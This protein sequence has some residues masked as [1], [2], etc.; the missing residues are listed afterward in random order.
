MG[1]PNTTMGED[2]WESFKLVG[3]DIEFLYSYLL[4][5]ETPLTSHELLAALI[6]ER[7]QLRRLEIERQHMAGGDLYQPKAKFQ[8]HQKLIFPALSWRQGEVVQVRAGENPEIGKFE[9][10]QVAFDDETH[11]EFAAS[12]SEHILNAPPK[13]VGEFKHL[14]I[15]TVLRI[16]GEDLNAALEEE[17]MTNSDFVR[18]AGRWFPRALLVDINVGHLN[19]A[20]AV[21]DMAS[22]GPLP[23]NNLLQQLE[24]TSEVNTKLQEFSMDHAL[25]EDPRFDEVGPAGDVLWFLKRLEPSEVTSTPPFLRYHEIDH[26]RSILT[27]EMSELELALD[28]E[29][30]PIKGKLTDQDDVEV[31]LIYPHWRAG[32]LPLSNRTRHLFPTAYEA[33]RVR[34]MLVDGETGNCFPGWVARENRYVFGLEE[35]YESHGVIPGSIVHVR[36]GHSPGEVIVFIDNHR[37][38]REWIRT[39]LVGSDGGM[40]YAMLKQIVST[41]VDERMAI[42]VPDK[43]ALDPAWLQPARDQQP[44]EK[45]VVNTVRDLA[46]LNPQGHTHFSEL[47]SAINVVRRVPPAPIMALLASHPWFIHVGDMY[48]RLSDMDA[49]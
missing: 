31:G 42:A 14:D 40:V 7:I 2:Y 9:V 48:Y 25:Q 17:L 44:F 49:D 20:E 11:R 46:R 30:S 26:D 18:I 5:T 33:P 27:P 1:I 47:Y 12:L 3:E 8:L 32:T 22:G 36:R 45:L 10:I 43:K 34:F 35:W 19:I 16:Y 6:Q 24:L 4:E 21:L 38:S 41:P 28:D 23:T 37:P 29:L 39:L 13:M 15:E